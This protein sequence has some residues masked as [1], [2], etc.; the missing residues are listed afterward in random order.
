MM[1]FL[2]NLICYHSFELSDISQST[3]LG[4]RDEEKETCLVLCFCFICVDCISLFF[5]S[6]IK[7]LLKLATKMTILILYS[8]VLMNQWVWHEIF[9]LLNLAL[10]EI[11]ATKIKLVFMSER[12][13]LH[14]A[15]AESPTQLR[16]LSRTESSPNSSSGTV[17]LP[18]CLCLFFLCPHILTPRFVTLWT[19]FSHLLMDDT[20]SATNQPE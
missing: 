8:L 9:H 14:D 20:R 10:K 13:V 1:S 18:L 7:V 16:L 17:P 4:S 2:G 15:P 6:K 11:P 3:A 19:P 5:F 12:K